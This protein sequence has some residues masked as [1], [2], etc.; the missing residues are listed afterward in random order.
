VAAVRELYDRW[1]RLYDW[2]PVL[3]LVR[4]ARRQT[5]ERMTLSPGD[6]VVDMGTGTGAN[7]PLLREA[8]GAEGS[9][10]GVDVS[11]KMLER[12]RVLVDDAVWENVQF[13]EG[14]IRDPPLD[15]P[16]DGILST[17]VVVMYSDP[18]RLVDTW[19]DFLDDGHLANLYAGPSEHR[20]AP[21]V[22][23]LLGLYLR[24]FEQGWDTM[25]DGSSPLD[26]LARRGRRARD[27][28]DRSTSSTRYDA[29]LF[30]LVRSDLGR[31]EPFRS[32]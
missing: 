22:N 5:V 16:V 1:A 24:L 7:L 25:S 19:T 8:V 21:V 18:A 29:Y 10:I 2:N 23:A 15:G 20:Y 31:F 30:G 26:V 27:A 3:A 11:P 4:P 17:F 14:D 32:R 9:V 13:L 28:L 6:T 12:A